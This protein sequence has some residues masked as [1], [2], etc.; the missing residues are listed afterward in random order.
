VTAVAKRAARPATRGR[1]KPRIAPPLP[2]RHLLP[3][4]TDCAAFLGIDLMPWQAR[5]GRYLTAVGPDGKWLFLEVALLVAR[6]NGKTTLLLPR[7][8]MDLRA[9]RKVLHTAQNRE[10]PRET[11]ELLAGALEGTAEVVKG[12]IRWANGQEVI[13]HVSGGR[14]T[15][16]APRHGVRGHHAD[17]V[18]QDEVREQR[19]ESLRAA[20]IPTLT[21]SPNKQTIYLSNA[22]DED[23]VVLNGLRNRK[24][25]RARL[26]YLEW[27]ADPSRGI[28]D[29]AGWAEANPALGHTIDIEALRDFRRTLAAST[30]ETEHLCRW[31]VSTRERLVD[32][33]AWANCA[34]REPLPAPK[35]PMMGISVDPNGRRASAAIAW[36]LPGDE[37]AY[38]LKV[39]LEATA[40]GDMPIDKLGKDLH[41]IA[42]RLGVPVV[43]FDPMTDG[44][45]AKHFR[46]TEPVSGGKFAVASSS[47]VNA[48][49]GGRVVWEDAG[50]VTDDL[51]WTTRKPTTEDRRTFEAV[52]AS[53]DRPITAALA[54]IRAIGLAT[55][56]KPA[57][58]K[59]M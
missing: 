37:I 15:L 7:I 50:A 43:G 12:G 31:V 36:Q 52:R 25:E 34:A 49:K 2:L 13:K 56:P 26:A 39:V 30:F 47:F 59:V 40:D 4:F 48:V 54:A 21:A 19:D 57:V 53:D 32:E 44:A 42:T 41:D 58:P 51:L 29:E 28:D 45:L 9:G 23:S 24:D 3:E 1:D 55:G 38:G 20:M 8:L 5:A 33:F 35:R 46:K 18:I 14:Y 10:I 11:F 16:V 17:T 27:S 6:Q 22:G